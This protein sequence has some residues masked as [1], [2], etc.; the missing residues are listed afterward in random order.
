MQIHGKTIRWSP[1]VVASR[2]P[3]KLSAATRPTGSVFG[4]FAASR[5]NV[6]AHTHTISIRT[7][8]LTS[9]QQNRESAFTNIAKFGG[10]T[11]RRGFHPMST[12][13]NPSPRSRPTAVKR[14]DGTANCKMFENHWHSKTNS[15]T[16][17][18]ILFSMLSVDYVVLPKLV[19]S[20][21]I[22]KLFFVNT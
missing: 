2:D 11:W 14:D 22:S 20:F 10:A 13:P 8:R 17:R 6:L 12:L 5:P 7:Q 19:T 9:L 21:A 1:I 15:I 18:R 16:S 3:P 4:G